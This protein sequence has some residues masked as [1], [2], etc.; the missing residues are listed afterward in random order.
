MLATPISDPNK[1]TI[2]RINRYLDKK[3][4]IDTIDIP[5]GTKLRVLEQFGFRD[6]KHPGMYETALAIQIPHESYAK[7]KDGKELKSFILAQIQ[8]AFK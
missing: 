6:S 5:E 4:G 7:A 2:R 8:E 3:R 1:E